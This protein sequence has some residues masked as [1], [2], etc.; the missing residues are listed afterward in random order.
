MSEEEDQPQGESGESEPD[1]SVE[2]PTFDLLVEGG[3]GRI[4]ISR[5]DDKSDKEEK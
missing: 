3:Y 4:D 5:K 2:P 1:R